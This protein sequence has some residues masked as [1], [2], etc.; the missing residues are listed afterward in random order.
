VNAA[1]AYGFHALGST[2]FLCLTFVS[3]F[4]LLKSAKRS[5]EQGLWI[6]SHLASLLSVLCLLPTVLTIF[7]WQIGKIGKGNQDGLVFASI[8]ICLPFVAAIAWT[9]LGGIAKQIPS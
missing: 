7:A 5:L 9:I 4:M 6:K 8:V 1:I 3:S 2:F